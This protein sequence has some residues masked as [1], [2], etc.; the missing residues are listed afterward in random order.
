MAA[1]QTSLRILITP[2]VAAEYDQ[3]MVKALAAAF[4]A[5]GHCGAAMD[6][7][8]PAEEIAEVCRSF[9]IDVVLQINRTRDPNVPFPLSVRHISWY[10]DVYPETQD[11][12]ANRFNDNDILYTLGDPAVLGLNVDLPCFQSSL[13]TGVDNAALTYKRKAPSQDIDLSLCGGLPAPISS[14]MFWYLDRLMTKTPLVGCSQLFWLFRRWLFT[15]YL[16]DYVPYATMQAMEQIVRSFYRPLRGEQDIHELAEALYQVAAQHDDPYHVIPRNRCE[17]GPGKLARLLKPYVADNATFRGKLL[18]FLAGASWLSQPVRHSP[19]AGAVCYFAQSYPRIMDRIALVEAASKV[20]DLLEL[21]GPGLEH[22][23]FARPYL[24]GV[25][26]TQDDLLEIYCRSKI[27]LSNNTHGLGLHSRTFECMA[28]EG[29]LFI[30]ESPHDN[31]VGGMLT[32]FE[33]GVHFGFYTPENFHD[34]AVRWLHDEKRRHTV[35]RAAKKVIK[36]RHCWHHRAQQII[37]DL[38]R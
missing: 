38:K 21:Y 14:N 37:D 7:P 9:S 30:N 36:E 8:L 33:P 24:K 16:P 4:N 35:G 1:K 26:K 11:G 18:R 32:S 12:F 5:I 28:V 2:N 23:D 34:E 19:V 6:T 17:R 22:H 15:R 29:F 10:Q 13:F 31:T 3:R 20:S 25:L 27:N